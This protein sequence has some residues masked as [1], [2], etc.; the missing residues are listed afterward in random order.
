MAEQVKAQ[1]VG[2]KAQALAREAGEAALAAW[3]G[4]TAPAGLQPAVTVSR[5]R[6]SVVGPKE[7]AAAMKLDVSTLPAWGGVDLGRQGHAVLKVT[8]VQPREPAAPELA[9]QE[10]RQYEQWW[11][12]AEGAAYYEHLKQRFKVDIKVPRPAP[13]SA[14]TGQN[15]G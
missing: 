4:G 13:K 11:T 8:G 3:K 10:L 1:L 6:P 5:D 12:S 14:T 9:A 15:N 7:V 2:D